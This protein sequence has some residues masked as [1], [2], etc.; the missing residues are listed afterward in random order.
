MSEAL[1][2]EVLMPE[3]LIKK[4]N[5]VKSRA[6]GNASSKL[7]LQVANSVTTYVLNPHVS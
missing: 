7:F 1:M 3:A 4:L 2:S 6:A 5:E